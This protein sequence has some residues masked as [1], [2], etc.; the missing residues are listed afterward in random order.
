MPTQNRQTIAFLLVLIA[1]I[2]ILLSAIGS[3]VTLT[4]IRQSISQ[5]PDVAVLAGVGETVLIVGAISGLIIIVC[6]LM[7][8]TGDKH[9]TRKWS[10]VAL[11]FAVISLA[12]GGGY[13]LGFI[14]GIVGSIM[15]LL[16]AV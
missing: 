1:G 11:I 13:A 16:P 6:A 5:S 9:R 14:M 4:T 3:I 2:V 10:I 7:L 12:A 8:H 15:G